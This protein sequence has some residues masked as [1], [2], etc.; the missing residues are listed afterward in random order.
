MGLFRQAATKKLAS[1]EQL[2][3]LACVISPLAWLAILTV[4]ALFSTATLWGIYG[5]IPTKAAGTGMITRSTGVCE[6]TPAASGLLAKLGVAVGGAVY[7]GEVLAEVA[8]PA[9]QEQINQ[10]KVD[11]EQLQAK[12][13]EVDRLGQ[14]GLRQRA[15]SRALRRKTL[16]LSQIDNQE[17]L[18]WAEQNVKVTEKLIQEGLVPE[19]SIIDARLTLQNVQHAF[20]TGAPQLQ[21]LAVEAAD[22][23][24]QHQ[25][26]LSD[27]DR[28]ITSKQMQLGAQRR[29]LQRQSRVTCPCSGRVIEIIA[30]VGD[31]VSGEQPIL[32]VEQETKNVN[33]LTAILFLSSE[34]GKK[35]KPGMNALINP[36]TVKATE[37]GGIK[38]LVTGASDH[39]VSS[40]SVSRLLANPDL[41]KS[42]AASGSQF[43]ITVSLVADAGT[44]SGFRWTSGTGPQLAIGS[45]TPCNGEIILD[46]VPPVSYVIPFFK[47]ILLG[48]TDE[49]RNPAR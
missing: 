35:V 45:G 25:A 8:L 41:G 42:L 20:D 28:Q 13:I 26:E 15:E 6:V 4:A 30:L 1:P 31:V 21:E 29:E 38:G 34:D 27:I 18:K 11:L 24:R 39:P 3:T 37:F 9:L 23:E 5:R 44:F 49:L 43:Q 14:E 16:E 17:R 12:R 7:Q 10:L 47:K 32:L 46:E 19:R 22:E 48:E 36:S 40:R 33:D 2:D